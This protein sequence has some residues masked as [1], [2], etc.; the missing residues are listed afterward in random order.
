MQERA[1]VGLG[2]T[3]RLGS[4]NASLILSYPGGPEYMAEAIN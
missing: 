1:S 3:D 4:E 2:L